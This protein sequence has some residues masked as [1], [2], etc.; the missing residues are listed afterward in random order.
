MHVETAVELIAIGMAA[1]LAGGLLGVGGGIV[2]IP[3]MYLLLGDHFGPNSFHLYKLAAIGTAI[4]ISTLAVIR[5]NRAKAIVYRMIPSIV[6]LAVVGV[7]VGVAGASRLSG[8]LT[9]VLRR[10]FGGFLEFVVLFNLYQTWR[11]ARGDAVVCD[12][13]P[14]ATRRVLIGLIVGLP[15]GLIAGMLGIGGGVWAVP[16]QRMF[17]GVRLRNAIA[18]SSSMIVAVAAATAATQSIAVANMQGVNVAD[19]WWLVLW[20]APGAVVGG[21]CGAGLTHRLP[22]RWLRHAFHALLVTAGIRLMLF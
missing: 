11:A 1:G 4:A 17:L 9:H 3:V 2:M 18:N 8:D 19:A 12:R 16:A 15:A 6:P 21:W 14:V 5:H 22:T 10:I 13:C 20:L 7:I